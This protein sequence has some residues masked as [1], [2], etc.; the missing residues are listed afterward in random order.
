MGKSERRR[1]G[2][3][4]TAAD[5]YGHGACIDVF[6]DEEQKEGWAELG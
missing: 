2:P 5:L 3:A 1:S 6:S 4:N